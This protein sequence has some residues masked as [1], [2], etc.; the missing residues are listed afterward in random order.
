MSLNKNYMMLLLK[1]LAKT[2]YRPT[3]I[4]IAAFVDLEIC[5]M[6]IEF[7]FA[8]CLQLSPKAQVDNRLQIIHLPI[9]G[10]HVGE[11]QVCHVAGWGS[12]ETGGVNVDDLRVAAVSVINMNVCSEVWGGLPGNVIC[13][14][15]YGTKKGFCQVRF[16]SWC[17]CCGN[18]L[19]F[20][21]GE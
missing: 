4:N 21:V 19:P 18:S 12:N 13:A 6:K 17:L 16:K 8:L 15:G 10:T 7:S 1:Q 5:W 14:G 3:N 2:Q 11:N 9:A 20:T